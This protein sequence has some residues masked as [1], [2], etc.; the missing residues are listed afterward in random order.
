MERCWLIKIRN[1]D[2]QEEIAKRAGIKRQYYGMIEKGIRTPSVEVAKKIGAALGFDWT[3]FFK[4][5]C[6][7]S[8]HIDN[9]CKYKPTGTDL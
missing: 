4:D 5:E 6:N 8:K 9:N 3:L 7:K 2:T 1:N